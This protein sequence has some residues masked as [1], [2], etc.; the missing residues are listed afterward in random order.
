MTAQ[1]MD[2]E[3]QERPL[4]R[5]SKLLYIVLLNIAILS[6]TFLGYKYLPS[7]LNLPSGAHARM[8]IFVVFGPLFA[9]TG[10]I[11]IALHQPRVVAFGHDGIKFGDTLAGTT[12]YSWAEIATFRLSNNGKKLTLRTKNKDLNETLSLKRLGITKQ[13]SQKL[14]VLAAEKLST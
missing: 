5:H 10:T 14:E 6:A 13:Q 4:S 12:F 2:F 9:L 11:V 3:L 1:Q 7:L 8:M